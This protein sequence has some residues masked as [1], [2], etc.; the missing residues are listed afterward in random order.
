MPVAGSASRRVL[1]TSLD[2]V[3]LGFPLEDV[4]EVLPAM[5]SSPLPHAPVVIAGVVDLRGRPLP[6]L[7]LRARL[8]RDR[9]EPDPDD[10]VVVCRIRDRHVGI[11]VDRALEVT[12]IGTAHLVAVSEVAQASHVDG[13]AL[14][15]DG[16]FF[17]YD[18]Q[19]FLDGDEA[20]T[21]EA[22]MQELGDGADR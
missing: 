15:P 16:M 11:W 13:V 6:L 14:G 1:L 18:V 10:H 21:L 8:G 9:A 20:L 22:A 3:R 19:S 4:V 2:D 5:A 17:V 7:D 12:S